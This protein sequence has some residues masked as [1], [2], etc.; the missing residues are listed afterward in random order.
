MTQQLDL[1]NAIALLLQN[2]VFKYDYYDQTLALVLAC[3]VGLLVFAINYANSDELSNSICY[4]IMSCI[5]GCGAVLFICYAYNTDIQNDINSKRR[6]LVDFLN[7]EAPSKTFYVRIGYPYVIRNFHASGISVVKGNS[8]D[9]M[10]DIINSV[11]FH[12]VSLSCEMKKKKYYCHTFFKMEGDNDTIYEVDLDH[13]VGT[14]ASGT[15]LSYRKPAPQKFQNSSA[16][17]KASF[18]SSSLASH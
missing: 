14:M 11:P 5:V 1:Q 9:D 12:I 6:E 2:F 8:P 16:S 17:E 15:P 18:T 3:L 7:V 10:E 4:G 13:L